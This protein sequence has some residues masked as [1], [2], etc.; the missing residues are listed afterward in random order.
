MLVF[1]LFVRLLRYFVFLFGNEIFCVRIINYL[2][3]FLF[4]LC[5]CI[6]Y[7]FLYF[8][9][10]YNYFIFIYLYLNIDFYD[11]EIC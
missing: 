9:E 2:F 3:I 5:I 10:N 1:I 11:L 4:Y 6:Y 7:R 8:K